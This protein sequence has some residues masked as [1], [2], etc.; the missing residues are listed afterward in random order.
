LLAARSVYESGM[1]DLWAGLKDAPLWLLAGATA[2]ALCVWLIAPLNTLVPETYRALV[3]LAAFAFGM[4]TVAR[5]IGLI[6]AFRHAE[7]LRRR[8][9]AKLRLAKVYRPLMVLFTDRHLDAATGILAP[10]WRHRLKNAWETF[11]SRRRVKAKLKGAWRAIWDRMESTSAEM[12]FG[13]SFPLEKIKEIAF[14]GQEHADGDLLDLI[15][16][17]DR[18][19]YEELPS[20]AAVT[21]AEYALVE[22]IFREHAS[23][24]RFVGR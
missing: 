22:H 10:H 15:R 14:A 18:S 16:R 5:A 8:E 12:E 9:L 3:P 17:A 19:R 20:D 6:V 1:K 11:I 7:V 23:L 21:D 13:G 24:E 2:V 4:L